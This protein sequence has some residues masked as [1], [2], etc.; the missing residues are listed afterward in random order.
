MVNT[1]WWLRRSWI[2]PLVVVALHGAAGQA[3]AQAATPTPFRFPVVTPTPFRAPVTTTAPSTTTGVTTRTTTTTP[4]PRA[5]GLPLELALPALAGGLAAIGGGSY[6][7]R[8][9]THAS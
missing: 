3:A 1:G 2:L 7:L 8:R 5:G 4:A 6:L 9:R